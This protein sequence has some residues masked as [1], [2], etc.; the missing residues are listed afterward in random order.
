MCEYMVVKKKSSH[1]K[2]KLRV[3]NQWNWQYSYCIVIMLLAFFYSC[4]PKIYKK[5]DYT[6][7]D[8]T[9]N[10]N[11]SSALRTDGIYVL[12]RIWTDENGETFK[13]PKEHRF[14]KFYTTGQCNLTLDLSNEIKTKEDYINVVNKDFLIERSTLFEGYYKLQDNK[15]V[16]QRAVVP[17]RQFE[18]RYGYVEENS[19]IIVK[20]TINGKGKFDD[21][22]FTNYYKEFYVFVPLDIIK[23]GEPQW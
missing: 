6:F 22:Y 19:L 18:Y 21:K 3:V 7:Y 16:I 13:E 10:L 2:S 20:S 15:I 8:K 1:F 11:I 4:T 23:E 5:S 17:R 9:F 14:Y 12:D